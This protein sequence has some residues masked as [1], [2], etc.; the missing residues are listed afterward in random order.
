MPIKKAPHWKWALVVRPA[1]EQAWSYDCLDSYAQQVG[2]LS[3]LLRH[4]Q[5]S[6]ADRLSP[7]TPPPDNQTGRKVF[8][9]PT[10]PTHP[11]GE[12]NHL[13]EVTIYTLKVNE[14]PKM[15]K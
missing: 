4:G 2:W 14:E 1:S 13:L 10:R 15:I 6:L 3:R 7:F 12:H 5:N 9:V 8:N 11:V